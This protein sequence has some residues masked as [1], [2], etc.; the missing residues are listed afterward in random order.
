MIV[1][2]SLQ[3]YSVAQRSQRYIRS[4]HD[5]NIRSAAPTSTIHLRAWRTRI[6]RSS[7]RTRDSAPQMTVADH[8]SDTTSLPLSP[9]AQQTVRFFVPDDARVRL[10]AR[11]LW[12][13]PC[14]L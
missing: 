7:L 2:A 12:T 6:A 10:D 9:D 8:D 11:T 3:I 5:P 13:W 4:F 1:C 14:M